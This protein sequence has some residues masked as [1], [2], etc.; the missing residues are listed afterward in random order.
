MSKTKLIQHLN[1]DLAE[2]LTAVIQYTI[3]ASKVTGPYRPELSKFF[4]AEITDELTHAQILANKIVALGGAPTTTP[5]PIP[6][7]HT[8]KEM[9]EAILA[10]EKRAVASY[11][12]RAEEAREAKEIGLAIQLENLIVDETGHKEEIERMLADWAL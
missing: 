12:A 7:A 8:N 2:E 9:L 4:L 3:Y 11:T 5:N 1:E 10:A 6:Q